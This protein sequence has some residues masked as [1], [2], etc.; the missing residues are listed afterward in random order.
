MDAKDREILNILQTDSELSMADLADRVALS[1]SAVWRRVRDLEDSGVIRQRVALLDA[2]ALGYGLTVFALVRTSQHSD[3]WF[4]RFERA[5]NSIPE[6]LDFYRM[7]GDIDYLLRVVARDISHYDEI[8]RRLIR[9]VDFADLSSTF[10]METLK[11][12]VALPLDPA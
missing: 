4:S 6:I 12:G 9:E 1:K 8:Y 11:S 7:S 5:V 10:V 2:R 3:A